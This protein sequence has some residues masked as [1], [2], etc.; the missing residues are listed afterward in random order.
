MTK[1]DLVILAGGRASRLGGGDKGLLMLDGR[2]VLERIIGR[3]R[4]QVARIALNANGDPT[5]FERFGLPVL[6]DPIAGQPGPLAGILA[7]MEWA[8]AGDVVTVPSDTPFLPAD[9]VPRLVAARGAAA[10]AVAASGGRSHP[11]AAL[12]PARLQH[13]LRRAI[14]EDGMRKVDHWVARH[15][16][17]EVPFATEPVDPFFNINRPEDLA[18][19][20]RIC[21]RHPAIWLLPADPP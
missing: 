10:I 17:V 9:L 13:E 11:V 18:E 5:R 15:R 3:L 2:T 12:W 1:P 6:P 19:A 20:A 21:A 14:V 8:G 16:P 4:P 7:A